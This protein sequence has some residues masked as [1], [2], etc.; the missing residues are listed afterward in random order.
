MIG[1]GATTFSSNFSS[2]ISSIVD[3]FYYSAKVEIAYVVVI[4]IKNRK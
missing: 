1:A 3:N 2:Y 4:L